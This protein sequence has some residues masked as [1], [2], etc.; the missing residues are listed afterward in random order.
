MVA[1]LIL[2]ALGVV[3][4]SLASIPSNA[5]AGGELVSIKSSDMAGVWLELH[6]CPGGE[7]HLDRGGMYRHFC[8]DTIRMGKWRFREGNKLILIH[9][10]PDERKRTAKDQETI[11][12]SRIERLPDRIF[13]YL[14]FEDGHVEKYMSGA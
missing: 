4:C 3:S 5:Q 9:D 14:R 6:G 12:I 8:F 13:I 7:L 10:V 1:Q 2:I 11:S